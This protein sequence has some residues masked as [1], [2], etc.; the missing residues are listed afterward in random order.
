MIKNVL[1]RFFKPPGFQPEQLPLSS[2]TPSLLTQSPG[3]PVDVDIIEPIVAAASTVT[4]SSFSPAQN[5]VTTGYNQQ[6]ALGAHFKELDENTRTIEK[7]RGRFRPLI[8]ARIVSWALHKIITL[9]TDVVQ[10]LDIKI[11]SRSNYGVLRGRL[12][13]IDMKFDK[14]SFAQLHVSGG[15]RFIIKG[16]ELRMRRFLFF[17]RQSVKKPYVIYADL[18][19]T[20][21]DIINSKVIRNLIQL[22][23]NTILE[24]IL[25]NDKILSASVRKVTIY[26]RRINAQ[27]TVK[28]LSD[29]VDDSSLI[30]L[31][32]EISTGAGMRDNGHVL[33]LKDVQATVALNSRLRTSVPYLATRPID[34]DL[35]EDCMIENL[36]IANK[37][38]WIRAASVISPITPLSVVEIESKALYRFD[39]SALLSSLLRLNGGICTRWMGA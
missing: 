31:D 23:V 17:N 4:A 35:G 25:Q 8:I 38:I 27:G 3:Q 5:L 9:R 16:L 2:A 37:N 15:G 11:A 13:T 29:R 34:I 19:L 28:V 36:V 10:G 30:S 26:A 7:E 18:L 21:Q 22:L 24:R 6:V 39:L 1:A 12:D 14:I 32:F 20:Q 33:F